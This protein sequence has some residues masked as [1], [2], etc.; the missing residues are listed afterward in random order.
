MHYV[1]RVAAFQDELLHQ[2]VVRKH[3]DDHESFDLSEVHFE[4]LSHDRRLG[5]ILYA[6]IVR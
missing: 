4:I 5:G 1:Q 6:S 3:G 2:F